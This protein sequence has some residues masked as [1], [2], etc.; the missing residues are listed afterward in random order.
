MTPSRPRGERRVYAR[1]LMSSE[2]EAT[3][4]GGP[5][6]EGLLRVG[7][8]VGALSR[9][10]RMSVLVDGRDYFRALELAAA[11]AREALYVSAWA[12]DRRAYLRPDPAEGERLTLERWARGLLARHR[13]L[14]LYVL[15]WDPAATAGLSRS[16]LP[17]FHQ[18]LTLSPRVKI[19]WDDRIPVGG[20]HHEKVVVVDDRVAFV[21]GFDPTVG[22]WDTPEHRPIDARRRD[23][24][25]ADHGPFHDAAGV[26]EGPLAR[27]LGRLFRERWRRS[28]GRRLRPPK[29][30]SAP[31]PLELRERGVEPALT[32][33]GVDVGFARTDATTTPTVHQVEALMLEAIARAERRIYIE[34]QYLTSHTVGRALVRRL[35]E[36][37]GPEV[38]IVG[39]R[40]PAGW[41]EEVTVGLLRW[42]VV[43]SLRA[44]DG[45]DRLRL[46]Y[47]MASL[48]AD[49]PTYVHAKLLVVDDWHVRV[50]SA[51][52][53]RRSLR[54]DTECD[55]ACVASEPEARARIDALVHR[56]VAE[57]LDVEPQLGRARRAA[58]GLARASHR[59]AAR[60]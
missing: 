58:R 24:Y 37:E 12:F 53:A 26:V 34:N 46:Y 55:L 47:P 50:G 31:A 21:G 6:G 56:L 11:T 4:S 57:H 5:R 25:G 3:S 43:E 23:D 9:G 36:R 38:V 22:R 13:T 15:L 52:V 20:A 40:Q 29:S 33:E 60:A 32:L 59:H 35:K 19:R 7:E 17:L 49:V 10:E 8:T 41:L 16:L 1:P 28:G 18:E 54:L 42:A 51:N 27:E 30:T 14:R 39:P 2:H 45:F 48:S 44:A